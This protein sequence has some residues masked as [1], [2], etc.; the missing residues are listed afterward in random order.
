M[1]LL[2]YLS[3]PLSFVIWIDFFFSIATPCNSRGKR[4][5]YVIS[6][7]WGKNSNNNNN[8]N[9]IIK[10]YTIMKID[11]VSRYFKNAQIQWKRHQ[12]CSTTASFS[13]IGGVLK[14]PHHNF[15]IRNTLCLF[16]QE[17][18]SERILSSFRQSFH[19]T[20]VNVGNAQKCCCW[21]PKNC[22]N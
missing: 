18:P 22:Q 13:A 5:T 10:I 21:K 14:R 11:L 20:K 15:P 3:K 19:Q 8:N 9:N 7:H 17:V 1:R 16:R 12:I 6:V 4:E 2:L